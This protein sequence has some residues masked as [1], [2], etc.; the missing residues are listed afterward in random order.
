MT[1]IWSSLIG[2]IPGKSRAQAAQLHMQKRRRRQ[3]WMQ[4]WGPKSEWAFSPAQVLGQTPGRGFHS[5]WPPSWSLQLE[6]R[7]R[8]TS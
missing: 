5:N 7:S 6:S 3:L 1:V 4:R 2:K 8:D